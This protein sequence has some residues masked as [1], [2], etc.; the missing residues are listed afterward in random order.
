[1]IYNWSTLRRAFFI[2]LPLTVLGVFLELYIGWNEATILCLVIGPFLLLCALVLA[3]FYRWMAHTGASRLPQDWEHFS[4][5]AKR[6]FI[7]KRLREKRSKDN[8]K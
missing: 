7:S 8:D 1:M 5:E 4:P 6:D 2:G 3:W